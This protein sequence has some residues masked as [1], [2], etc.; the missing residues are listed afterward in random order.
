[1]NAINRIQVEFGEPE[2]PQQ[3]PVRRRAATASR[4][5]TVVWVDSWTNSA[6]FTANARSNDRSVEAEQFIARIGE[7]LQKRGSR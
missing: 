6:S 5:P 1:M 3:I 7:A 2:T 4:L